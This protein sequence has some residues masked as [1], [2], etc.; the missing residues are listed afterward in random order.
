MPI[1]I[2]V[3]MCTYNRKHLLAKALDALFRQ[4]FPKDEY[5]IVLIDDGSTDGTGDFVKTLSPP[6]RLVYHYQENSGLTRG[7][8]KGVKLANGHIV[9]FVDDDIIACPNLLAE[10]VRTHERFMD[11]VVRGW[12]N[13]IDDLD[14]PGRPRYN[15]QDFST[16]FFWTSNVSATRKHLVQAGLFDEDFCEYGW[17]DLELGLRLRRLGLDMKYNKKALVYHYKAPWTPTVV[18]SMCRQAQAKGRTAVIFIEKHPTW[19]VRLATGVHTMRL[20]FHRFFSLGGRVERFYDRILSGETNRELKGFA[21][22]CAQQKVIFRYFETVH[23]TLRE[24]AQPLPTGTG[25]PLQRRPP[26]EST[27]S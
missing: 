16:A 8:N 19:R 20:F 10:H 14:H 12:V 18:A 15:L 2:S 23:S 9:L 17:E 6:C 11:H 26:T 24:R 4:N 1:K 13:H 7:R 27:A 22:F 3:Q 5:E 21:L 25:E